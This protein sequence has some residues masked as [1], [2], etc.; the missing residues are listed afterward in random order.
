[1]QLAR[2]RLIAREIRFPTRAPSPWKNRN[3][4]SDRPDNISVRSRVLFV[5]V[6]HRAGGGE[7]EG[8]GGGEGGGG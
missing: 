5:V 3:L 4:M 1:M 6:V 7:E 2:K 8:G